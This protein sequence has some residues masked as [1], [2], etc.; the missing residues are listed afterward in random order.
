MTPLSVLTIKPQATK[1]L[2]TGHPW[3]FSN[4]LVRLPKELE[5]GRLVDVKSR[6]GEWIGRGYFN[7][8]S[9][10]AVRLL[11]REPVDIDENFLE[12]KISRAQAFREPWPSG[13]EAYRVVFGE[14]DG[15]PGLIIDRYGSVLAVQF[16][17]AGMDRLTEPILKV[18]VK[19]FQPV[20]VVA[21]ND[22]AARSL[23][24]LPQEKRLLYGEV[25][26]AVVIQKNGL[27]FEVDVLEGQKTGFFLDQSENYRQMDGPAH[28]ARVLDAFCYTGAWGLHAARYG[29]K[30][31][32]G[33]DSSEKAVL[34][35]QR[36]AERNGLT[37]ICNFIREDVFEGLRRLHAAGERFDT[38][39]LDPPA[40]AK[41]RPKVRQ[42]IRGYK[43]INR[44]AMMLLS[45]A[46]TLI[47]C[48]CSHL[49][50]NEMFREMLVSAAADAK[51]SFYITAWRTQGRDHPVDLS[52][53]ETHYLKCVILEARS[54]GHGSNGAKQGYNQNPDYDRIGPINE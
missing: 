20:A 39:I 3:I 53:P 10:I 15:L 29:A 28:N 32:I 51:K 27:S 9:L 14:A 48:S 37:S 54:T 43:E 45:P 23:E 44:L 33:L 21:R 30:E 17:T 26:P 22:T 16:L 6:S 4:E 12:R 40:F 31:V 25:P 42:A 8:R 18:L 35:A 36:N 5:P 24:G 11:S 38:I 13:E 47:T 52:I 41:S 46:G 7:P 50:G 1:R 34:Q 19:R 49:V 2:K